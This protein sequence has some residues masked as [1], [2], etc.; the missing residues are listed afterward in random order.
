MGFTVERFD[1]LEHRIDTSDIDFDD[2]RVHP[3]S[4]PVSRCLRYMHDVEHHAICYLRDLLVTRAHRD[5]E[6]VTSLTI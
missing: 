6:I 3:L 1:R 4:E 2:F 5:P